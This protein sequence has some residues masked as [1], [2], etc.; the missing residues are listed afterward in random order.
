[1]HILELN[2]SRTAMYIYPLPPN[3]ATTNQTI[4]S[5]EQGILDSNRNDSEETGRDT[6]W[7]LMS[8]HAKRNAYNE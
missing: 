8:F 1:M 4:P 7:G 5:R 6:I 3:A 2:F